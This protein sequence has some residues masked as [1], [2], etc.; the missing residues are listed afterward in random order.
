MN[1]EWKRRNELV[2]PMVAGCDAAG[3]RGGISG[4]SRRDGVL[5]HRFEGRVIHRPLARLMLWACISIGLTSCS[6]CRISV[7]TDCSVDE[8]EIGKVRSE[9][10]QGRSDICKLLGVRRLTPIRV[11][12]ARSGICNAYGGKVS[13]PIDYVRSDTAV[14][15]HEIT[16]VLTPRHAD[17][18]FLSEG[19][20]VYMQERFGHH[21]GFPNFGQPVDSLVKYM[22]ESQLRPLEQLND[23]FQVFGRVGSAER[24]WAYVEAGSFIKYLAEA[25][26]DGVLRALYH[27]PS[28]DYQAVCGKELSELEKE[29]LLQVRADPEP[30]QETGGQLFSSE[31]KKAVRPERWTNISER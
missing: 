19:L 16:H 17:N 20:A 15:I 28:V 11:H 27:S 13:L 10:E 29:W 4:I 3:P 7:D 1:T 21:R 14:A 30:T 31:V 5:P 9:I 26:G 6:T 8:T 23:D 25:Y 22:N 2:E 18:R 12:I 24:R